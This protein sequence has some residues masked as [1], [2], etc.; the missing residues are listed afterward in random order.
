MDFVCFNSHQYS[1]NMKT[2]LL[3]V[4]ALLLAGCHTTQNTQTGPTGQPSSEYTE[5]ENSF[6]YAL[7][8]QSVQEEDNVFLSPASVAVAMDMLIPG[9]EGQTKTELEAI[10]PQVR[11]ANSDQLKSA[12]AIWLNKGFEV[13]PSYL[14]ANEG[15]EVFAG[16]IKAK[17]V[18]N[19]ASD[20]TNGK[21]NNVLQDPVNY[22]MI[23]TNALYFKDEWEY[24]F[25]PYSTIPE[26][27]HGT[28]GTVDVDMMHQTTHLQ[29]TENERLQAVR[30]N[31]VGPYCMDI[32]LPRE[33][34]DVAAIVPDIAK[35]PL[36]DE[37]RKKVALALPK[38]K[39]EYEKTLNDY[40]KAMGVKTCF[41]SQADFSR[42]SKT[43][44]LVDLV[45]QNTFLAIDEEGTEAA[46]V[47]VI[48][49]KA[50]MARPDDEPIYE[51]QIDH[52]FI[53]MI[54][55]SDTNRILFYG[56]IKDI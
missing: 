21:I 47:T 53:L 54:R 7:L 44:V 12:S 52:P 45:K 32:Y 25:K 55:E 50:M 4:L 40:L 34:I 14:R 13:L 22:C 16:K 33:G 9:A 28:K 8:S 24:P 18:N 29:Y 48:A 30:L 2:N 1:N 6:A 20:H 10:V 43:P 42:L 11:I 56:V 31:Y 5:T 37:S 19:W 15:A 46:A 41:S 35:T 36:S 49:M 26:P 3:L 23:L 38:V 27:F 39:M 17:T 51:M